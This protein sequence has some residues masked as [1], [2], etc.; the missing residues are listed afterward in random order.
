[1]TKSATQVRDSKA[2]QVCAR[3]FLKASPQPAKRKGI[4]RNSNPGKQE[5]LVEVDLGKEKGRGP[6][7]G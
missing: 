2:F 3:R 1:M 6:S 4:V 5:I 7:V